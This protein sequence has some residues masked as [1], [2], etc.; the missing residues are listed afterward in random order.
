MQH[1]NVEN[2]LINMLLVNESLVLH[3]FMRMLEN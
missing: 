2:M 3:I 1:N